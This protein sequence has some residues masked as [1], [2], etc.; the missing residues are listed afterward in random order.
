MAGIDPSALAM[1]A[2]LAAQTVIAEATLDLGAVAQ[3][4]IAQ[5][6]TGD[7][8]SALVLPPSEGVDHISLFGQSLPAQLP[9]GI[10]PGD[11][12]ALQVTGFSPTQIFVRNLGAIDPQNPPQTANVELPASNAQLPAQGAPVARGAVASPPAANPPAANLPAASA[13]SENLASNAAAQGARSAIAPPVEVF[14]AASVQ[15]AR[16]DLPAAPTQEPV[17]GEGAP[18]AESAASAPSTANATSSEAQPQPAP[19]AGESSVNASA[20]QASGAD[21]TAASVLEARLATARGARLLP[22]PPETQQAVP[23]PPARM[24]APILPRGTPLESPPP[25]ISTRLAPSAMET[26]LAN[27][28]AQ[29]LG[30][31]AQL[32]A[33]LD[34]PA[35]PAMIAAARA[36]ANAPQL[37]ATAFARAQ[38]VLARLVAQPAVTTVRSAMAFVS[39]LDPANAVALPQQLAAYVRT[40]LGSTEGAL[41]TLAKNLAA[42]EPT[43]SANA[44]APGVPTNAAANP[45]PSFA[46]AARIAAAAQ[47]PNEG[48]LPAATVVAT[49]AHEAAV[50][51]AQSTLNQ[52]VK[53][54]LVALAQDPQSASVPGAANVLGEAVTAIT[55]AQIH[56]LAANVN[57]DPRT[58]IVPLPVFFRDGGSPTQL[59]IG[60]D[61]PGSKKAMDAD[62]FTLGFLLDTKT[63]GTVAIEVETSG[64]A[65]SVKVKTERDGAAKRFRDAFGVLRDRFE[66]LRYRV[67]GMNA[68]VAARSM[69]GTA[70]KKSAEEAAPKRQLDAQA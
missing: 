18:A 12:L 4:V 32:L 65:V 51:S 7:L 14:V 20:L 56:L 11:T 1:Q 49:P 26:P 70:V 29:P 57:A 10:A 66:S 28:A 34:V 15:P 41:A 69:P 54:A 21:P 9:P 60:R 47:H 39:T 64:R 36:A 30:E 40:I 22:R 2:V 37:L 16:R 50:L 46:E 38:S 44:V 17:L 19:S 42:L 68:A 48:V 55:A 35:T 25:P 53:S 13:Q 45:L 27:V 62:N 58:L 24:N 43:A 23:E 8:L 59:R 6:K 33:R 52:D 31:E 67:A 3:S 61:A 63:L 5:L